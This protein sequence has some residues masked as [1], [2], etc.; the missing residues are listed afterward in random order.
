MS[1]RKLS[2]IAPHRL[3]LQGS[4]FQNLSHQVQMSERFVKAKNFVMIHK[5]QYYQEM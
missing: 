1:H 2:V 4:G 3:S 5:T